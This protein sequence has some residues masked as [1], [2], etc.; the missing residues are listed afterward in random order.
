MSRTGILGGSFNPP[1]VGHLVGARCAAEQ[2]G[3]QRVLLVPLAEPAH[4]A[5]DGDP[6]AGARLELCELAVEGDP[7]LEA[8]DVEVARGGTSY[9][10]DTLEQLRGE[11][12]ADPV[13]ILGADAALGLAGWREPGRVLELSSLAVAPREGSEGAGEVARQVQEAFPGAR[14]EPFAMPLIGISSS[15]LRSRL[16]AGLAIRDMVPAAVEERILAGGWYGAG[17]GA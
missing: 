4:R 2:L 14:V 1:H 13:L 7:L 6:G 8:C 5:L 16:A 3:L 11:G 10:V 12:V 9:T 17:G 15:L